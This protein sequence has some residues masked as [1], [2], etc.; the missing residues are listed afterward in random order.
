MF[1]NIYAKEIFASKCEEQVS[2]KL[3][4]LAVGMK[5]KCKT[6]IGEMKNKL[7]LVSEYPQT[8]KYPG[9]NDAFLILEIGGKHSHKKVL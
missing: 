3:E 7:L 5:L 2:L 6:Y 9:I 8:S 1:L 4:T